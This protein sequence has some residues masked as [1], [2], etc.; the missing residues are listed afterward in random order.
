MK[1][2]CDEYVNVKFPCGFETRGWIKGVGADLIFNR[3]WIVYLL[4]RYP[5]HEFDCVIL[6]ESCIYEIR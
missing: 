1:Y 5:G 6:D 2:K 3:Q 4:D